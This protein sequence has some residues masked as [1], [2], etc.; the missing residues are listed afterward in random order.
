MLI[1]DNTVLV[2]DSK[3][4]LEKLVDEFGRVCRRGKLKLSVTKSNVMQSTRDGSV[5]EMNIK[6][7]GLVF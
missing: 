4:K 3:K 5:G 2:A 6:I 7:D 1:A